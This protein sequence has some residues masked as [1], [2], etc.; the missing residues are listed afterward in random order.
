MQHFPFYF[1][2][3]AG[4]FFLDVDDVKEYLIVVIKRKKIRIKASLN[5]SNMDINDSIHYIR[6]LPVDTGFTV[7]PHNNGIWKWW[8]V[9]HIMPVV[10]FVYHSHFLTSIRTCIPLRFYF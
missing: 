7:L 8:A 1:H 2:S 10:V 4:T 6:Y 5:F 9:A 3:I